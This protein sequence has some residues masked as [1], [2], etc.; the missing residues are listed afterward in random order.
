[1]G[2][3]DGTS[4][5]TGMGHRHG[6][7]AGRHASAGTAGLEV[8]R[9]TKDFG[10]RTAAVASFSVVLWRSVRLPRRHGAGKSTA[11]G[12]LGTRHSRKS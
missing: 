7:E 4:E 11:A 12:M 8:S 1:M 10:G 6:D 5:L 3:D 2:C 9:R